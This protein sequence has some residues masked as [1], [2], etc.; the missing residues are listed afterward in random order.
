[1]NGITII[2]EHFCRAVELKELIVFGIFFTLLIFGAL[3]LYRHMY[4]LTEYKGTK[5]T[6]KFCSLTLIVFYIMFWGLQIW[7]YNITH[8]EYTI[9]IDNSVNFNEFYDKYEIISVDGE[10]YR[11]IE[12]HVKE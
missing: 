1:M 10:K 11:V 8:M 12:K 2:E 7:E 4:K 6:I 3:L 5:T 9:T